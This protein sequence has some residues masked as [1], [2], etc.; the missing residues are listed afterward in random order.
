M[1]GHIRTAGRRWAGTTIRPGRPPGVSSEF[2]RPTPTPSR[3]FCLPSRPGRKSRTPSGPDAAPLPCGPA[4]TYAAQA[5][6]QTPAPF[7]KRQRRDREGRVARIRSSPGSHRPPLP[8]PCRAGR[9]PWD[10]QDL[11]GPPLAAAVDWRPGAFHSRRLLPSD[12]TGPLVLNP[13]TSKFSFQPNPM[14]A[15][16]MLADETNSAPFKTPASLWTRWRG[17]SPPTGRPDTSPAPSW[18]R[19]PGPFG[20]RGHVPLA[21]GPTGPSPWSW[22]SRSRPGTTRAHCSQPRAGVRPAR[23]ARHRAP[24]GRLPF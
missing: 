8:W 2:R 20:P 10:R 18:S 22:T 11:V 15:N 14:L 19:R 5:R 17:R 12:A 9:C 4:P 23:P 6:P 3:C 24:S 16:S 21:P 1:P 13:R 7:S